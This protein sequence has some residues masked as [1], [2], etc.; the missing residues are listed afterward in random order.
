M[1]NIDDNRKHFLI[2]TDGTVD[3][4]LDRLKENL[5]ERGEIC[6][7]VEIKDD[8]KLEDLLGEQP[9]GTVLVIA[10]IPDV[11]A[12]LV[13]SAREAGYPEADIFTVRE[14]S[15]NVFC[16]SCHHIS[17]TGVQEDFCCPNCGCVLDLSDHYSAYYDAVLGYPTIRK[18]GGLHE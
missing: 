1:L 17:N 12:R 2:L 6:R 9:I 7:Y 18:V 3:R 11:T 5:T 16:G 15:K 10:A 14:G 8:K 4:L 13:H